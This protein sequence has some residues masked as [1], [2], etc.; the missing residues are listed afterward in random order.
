MGK[1]IE[2]IAQERGHNVVQRLGSG[3]AGETPSPDAD[4]V[5]EFSTPA[6][7]V[8]NIESCLNVGKPVVVGTTG[9]LDEL[10]SITE[11][12][13]ATNGSL[14][15]ASNFSVGVNLFFEVNR[16]LAALMNGRSEYAATIEETHHIHK[17]DAPSG[18]AISL[19]NDVIAEVD[20]LQRWSEEEAP[21]TLPITSFREN[22]VPGTHAVRYRSAIDELTIEHKAHS[23]DGFALGAVLAAEWLLGKKGVF[24]MKDLLK[25]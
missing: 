6:T 22:E 11:R 5:I 23:R 14:L 3:N 16:K 25:F 9:W 19:A 15:Y 8:S 24:T 20:D 10:P 1:A 12:V 7:A 18:T 21:G 13:N 2:R 17:L 4:V